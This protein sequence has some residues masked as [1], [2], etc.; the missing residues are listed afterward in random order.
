MEREAGV[1]RMTHE[2]EWPAPY[3]LVPGMDL[4]HQV[5]VAAERDD[6]PDREGHSAGGQ[7]QSERDDG[8]RNRDLRSDAE[9]DDGV[10]HPEEVRERL[11]N[12]PRDTNARAALRDRT[13]AGDLGE[14]NERHSAGYDDRAGERLGG[15][16][17]ALRKRSADS[18]FEPSSSWRKYAYTSL[19]PAITARR[20]AAQASTESSG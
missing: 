11:R 7:R 3:E 14:H 12:A 18:A 5:V 16:A 9:R 1:D 17:S 20:R 10:G 19:P 6:R 8:I 4:E 2:T 13:A 15:H